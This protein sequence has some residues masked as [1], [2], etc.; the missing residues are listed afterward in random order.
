VVRVP[1]FSEGSRSLIAVNGVHDRTRYLMPVYG[2]MYGPLDA[3]AMSVYRRRFG[4]AV[5]LV[6]LLTGESQRRQ[7]AVHCAVSVLPQR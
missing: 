5:T 1:S 3:V 7:G 2:G 4:D 6:P